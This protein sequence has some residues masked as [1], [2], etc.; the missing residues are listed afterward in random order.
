LDVITIFNSSI[1]LRNCEIWAIS[2]YIWA[3][4]LFIAMW[5]S[6]RTQ[7]INT[8]YAINAIYF[9]FN[10]KI[11]ENVTPTHS[12]PH[13]HL[14]EIGYFLWIHQRNHVRETHWKKTKSEA[15]IRQNIHPID[16]R[17][18]LKSK[19]SVSLFVYQREISNHKQSSMSWV[20]RI[21]LNQKRKFSQEEHIT[22]RV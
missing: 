7:W 16:E 21:C 8:W 22:T 19:E 17:C 1:S 15:W 11:K 20:M 6:K 4:R 9:S 2:W 3:A 5:G 14:Q 12:H 13:T 18:I 10:Q